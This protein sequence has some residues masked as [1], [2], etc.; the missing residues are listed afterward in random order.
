MLGRHGIPM[1]GLRI[2]DAGT[3][4]SPFAPQLLQESSRDFLTRL[5][6]DWRLEIVT[7]SVVGSEAMNEDN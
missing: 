1:E 2:S 3:V 7:D 4:S 5:F 6:W